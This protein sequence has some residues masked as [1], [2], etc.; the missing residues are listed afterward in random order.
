MAEDIAIP[1]GPN[2][3]AI[4]V[5][6]H[7]DQ[8]RLWRRLMEMATH[9]A[10][11]NGGVNRQALSN[12]DIAARALLRS[13][14]AELGLQASVDAIGNLFLRLPGKREDAAP[15]LSGSHLDSQ[16]C[17][18][19]FDGSYGVLAALEGVEAMRSAG[20]EPVRSVEI[21]AWT[22]EEGSRFAPGMMGST[23]FAGA[24]D[25]DRVLA[26]RGKDGTSVGEALARM[27]EVE[28]DLPRRKLG[29]R[30][31]AFIEAHIEQG[32]VLEAEGRIVGV[33]KGIAGKR[34]FGVSVT[35]EKGH[36]GT[37]PQR[38]RKDAM[39][40][41]A[42]MVAAIDDALAAKGEDVKFTVGRFEVEPNAPSVIPSEVRFSIDLRHPDANSL[43]KLGDWIGNLC[44]EN[45]RNCEVTVD[46][47][48][49]DPPL[50]FPEP[51][52]AF[53]GASSTTLGIPSME[54]YSGSGHDARHL[55]YLCPTGM[56]FVPSRGGISHS[57]EEWTEPDHLADGARTLTVVLATL[58]T[59]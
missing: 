43:T 15:I 16:P 34:V 1:Q 27:L 3:A 32:P 42:R 24:R 8:D 58:A 2:K 9:G 44:E 21:V 11:D 31:A 48:S 55:H 35:G 5:S 26:V 50:D 29:V 25:L 40:A 53:I 23:V 56:I 30:P 18:G 59:R 10:T 47:L 37:V 46:E 4:A 22:N 36:A 49:H 12:E 33:V 20:I 19:K 41:A 6:R 39:I 45:R 7:V 52:R 28:S 57:E 54:I 38:R 13:W 51:M 17:G 14:G